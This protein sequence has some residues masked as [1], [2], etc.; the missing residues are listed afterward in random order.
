ML[1]AFSK[2]V[3]NSD[4]KEQF[5]NREV[6]LE[7]LKTFISDGNNRL[8][9]VN[10]ILSNASCMVSDAVS[11]MICENP[12][13]ITEGGNCYKNRRMA[14]CLRDGEIIL[15]Y[16]S[17]AL[18]IGDSSILDDK[19]LHGLRDTYIA[20]GVPTYSSVRA[21]SI[22]KAQSLAFINSLKNKERNILDKDLSSLICEINTYFDKISA[23]MR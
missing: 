5:S 14:A 16:I 19:C 8:D 7:A 4:T 6:D 13:L 12:S 3:I 18:L 1:D 9:A 17:Y 11:G 23:A 15:R 20:L 2:V 22:L 21:T 10:A